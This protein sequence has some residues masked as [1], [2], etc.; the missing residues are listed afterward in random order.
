MSGP[1]R[2]PTAQVVELTNRLADGDIAQLE[3]VRSLAAGVAHDFNNLLAVILSCG[4]FA[5]L[6]LESTSAEAEA[7]RDSREAALRAAELCKLILAFAGKRSA[8]SKP[9]DVPAAVSAVI[10]GLDIPANVKV[11]FI[12]PVASPPLTADPVLMEQLLRALVRNAVE[13]CEVDGGIVVVSVQHEDS[14]LCIDVRDDGVGMSEE[15]IA[16]AFEPF[17]TTHFPSRG[18]G[19]S[20][21]QGIAR[22]HDGSIELSSEL[23][24]GTHLRVLLPTQTRARVYERPTTRPLEGDNPR[25]VLVVDDEHL[26]A[27]A[28]ER[29]LR[30]A[31]YTV[32]TVA[33]GEAAIEQFERSPDEFDLVILDMTMPGLDGAETFRRLR[34]LVPDQR[35]LLSSG[36]H[37]LDSTEALVGTGHCWFLAKP[38]EPDDILNALDSIFA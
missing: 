33:S 12:P 10:A 24:V 20:A 22:S 13:A 2:T 35:V 5:E 7:L 19:L 9:V 29:I 38:Y 31:G 3:A 34:A 6:A 18:L 14:I 17:F 8:L 37:H 16:R 1:K 4:E 15:T 23:S 30:A 21:A 26:V 32:V 27:R 36:Y 11:E 28:I 25:H